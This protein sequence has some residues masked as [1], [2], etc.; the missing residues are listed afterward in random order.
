VV[1]GLAIL[2]MI[3]IVAAQLYLTLIVPIQLQKRNIYEFH[4]EKDKVIKQ[5]DT[6]RLQMRKFRPS[7]KIP[8]GEVD[9]VRNTMNQLV[10]YLTEH[11][12]YMNEKQ[13]HE[14][15]QIFNRFNHYLYGW[16]AEKPKFFIRE[17]KID[18]AKLINSIANELVAEKKN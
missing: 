2:M 7:G 16:K 1:T 17:E 18:Q 4:V 3:F 11:Q 15:K 8:R 6:F 14:V 13:V 9:L 5:A 12:D 10:I